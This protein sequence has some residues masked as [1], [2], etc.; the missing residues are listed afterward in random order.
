MIDRPYSAVINAT[1]EQGHQHRMVNIFEVTLNVSVNHP[2][3]GYQRFL[4]HR[5][6]LLRTPLRAKAVN[7]R[8][9]T[10][11]KLEQEI[12]ALVF[13]SGTYR[14]KNQD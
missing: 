6:C 8:I 5:H 14:T 11:E 7:R 2:P 4:H 12:L 10:I 13:G 1:L 9:P 3:T